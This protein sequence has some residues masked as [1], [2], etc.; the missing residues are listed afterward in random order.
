MCIAGGMNVLLAELLDK[1]RR[2][3]PVVILRLQI[4]LDSKV[5]EWNSGTQE[6]RTVGFASQ[7]NENRTY[8]LLTSF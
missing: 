5:Q 3:V 2:E 1:E 4:C 8:E 6:W 7:N